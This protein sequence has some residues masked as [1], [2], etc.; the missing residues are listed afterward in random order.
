MQL[1]VGVFDFPRWS[2]GHDD[3]L[4]PTLEVDRITC[5]E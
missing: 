1:M 2:N 5:R 3:Q 4:V